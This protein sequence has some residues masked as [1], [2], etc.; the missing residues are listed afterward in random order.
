MSPDVS[1]KSIKFATRYSTY[2]YISSAQVTLSDESESPFFG[3][4]DLQS[5][6][7]MEIEVDSNGGIIHDFNA[8]GY[9]SYGI[10]NFGEGYGGYDFE[11]NGSESIDWSVIRYN[12][13][14]IS[15]DNET[16]VRTV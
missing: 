12:L 11:G 15:F 13:E 4:D 1:L 5:F 7:N 14:T 3:Y 16:P 9:D 8:Y 2:S 10:Y 6:H